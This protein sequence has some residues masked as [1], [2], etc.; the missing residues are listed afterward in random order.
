[1]PG[2]RTC[3]QRVPWFVA[4]RP[5]AYSDAPPLAPDGRAKIVFEQISLQGSAVISVAVSLLRASSAGGGPK[6]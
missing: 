4:R 3:S 2:V 1:M 5:R 6:G